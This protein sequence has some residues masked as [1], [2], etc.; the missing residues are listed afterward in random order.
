MSSIVGERRLGIE[1]LGV[2]LDHVVLPDGE[3]GDEVDLVLGGK[4][5]YHQN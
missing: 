4:A 2:D 1:G 5:Y 3:E